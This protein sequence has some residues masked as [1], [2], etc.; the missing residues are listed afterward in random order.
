MGRR[1][2]PQ[3]IEGHCDICGEEYDAFFHCT[4]FAF[5]DGKKYDEICFAC[6][7]VPKPITIPTKENPEEGDYIE[8]MG[9]WTTEFRNLEEMLDDGFDKKTA[10][11]SIKAV[12]S[13]IKLS[14]KEVND[15]LCKRPGKAKNIPKVPKKRSIKRKKA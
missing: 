15:L 3:N 5:I 7:C 6:G 14:R 2:K 11:K 8:F 4:D 1:K 13:L 9:Q 12:G 10:I